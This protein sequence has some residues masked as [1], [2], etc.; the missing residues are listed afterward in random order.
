MAGTTFINLYSSLAEA[1]DVNPSPHTTF[2]EVA[3]IQLLP[4][5]EVPYIQTTNNPNGVELE[6]WEVFVIDPCTLTETDITEYFEVTRVFEDNNGIGQIDWSLTNIPLDFGFRFMV[7]KV[8]QLVGETFYSN[9]FQLTAQNSNETARLDYRNTL[10]DTMQ[11]IQLRMWYWQQ[12][13]STEL[14]TYYETS[15]KN[16]VSVLFKSQKHERWITDIIS[17]DLIIKISDVF[18]NK[19]VYLNYFRAY[20]FD[21]FEIKEHEAAENFYEQTMKISFNK[22]D[23]YDPFATPPPTQLLPSIVLS[24]VVLNG[25]TAQYLFTISNFT[26]GSVFLQYTQTPLVEASWNSEERGATSPQSRPFTQTGTWYFRVATPQASSNV[27]SF[28][29]SDTLVANNDKAKVIKGG[30]V[31][32][33]VLF[34][35]VLS[36]VVTIQNI[37]SPINGTAVLISGNKIRYTHNDSA[38]TADSFTYEITNGSATDEAT[39]SINVTG[40]SGTSTAFLIGSPN[41]NPETSCGFLVTLTRYHSGE[42]AAPTLADF[43]YTDAAMTTVVVGGDNYYAIA[44][45]RTIRINNSGQVTDLYICGA[46]SA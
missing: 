46:G 23:I 10:A 27:L 37:S 12:L 33:S 8:N 3:G 42:S 40:N 16:T 25:F 2:Y 6:D 36:G 43:I 18:E 22:S 19:F 35:D 31:D 21:A 26:P 39:V 7:L 20:L 24:N 9:L 38:T 29:V 14:S 4:N 15:T 13:K 17:N 41:A 1:L 34:N 5:Q 32:I 11:S 44:N 45:G 28:T 30:V